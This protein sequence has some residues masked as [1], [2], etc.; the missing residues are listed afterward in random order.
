MKKH[1]LAVIALASFMSFGVVNK[2]T[3]IKVEAATI[4][5]NDYSTADSLHASSDASGLLAELRRLTSPGKSGAYGD[6]WNTYYS[7]FTKSDNFIMDYYSNISKFTESNRDR[8]S[9]GNKEGEYFNREHSV[10]QSW[11]GGGTTTGTQGTDP[12]I[13]IPSDKM[14]NGKRGSMSYGVVKTAS[15]SSA[16]GFSKTGLS[17]STAF[18]YSGTVFEP[19]DSV[20]G[21]LARNTLYAIAKYEKSYSWTSD[22]GSAIFSGNSSTNFGLTS[23]GVKLLTAWN[24]LDKPDEW[25]IGVNERVSKIQKNRNPF[26]DHPE[27]VNTL[28]GNVSGMTPYQEDTSPKLKISKTSLDVYTTESEELTGYMTDESAIT[29]SISDSTVASISSTTAKTITVTGLKAGTTTI[30]LS[31]HGEDDV[32]LEKTCTVTVKDNKVERL[33]ISNQKTQ[34]FVGDDFVKPTV[35]AMYTKGN[36]IDVT[37]EATFSG[38]N[39]TTA[40][41]RTISVSYGGKSTTYNVSI[42]ERPAPKGCG[43]NVATTSIV[44]SSLALAG[45]ITIVIVSITRKKRTADK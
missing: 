39:S 1:I 9:G 7:C 24:N 44:L 19:D 43:G 20:K 28:W 37:N 42:S 41:T 21:D 36:E 18:G 6:L 38:F 11:W 17:D 22:G 33:S 14:V 40:G 45:I 13:V 23:Y 8:G 2:V 32:L 3:T 10:P 30:T 16:N 35:K 4:D 31:G 25:E 15:F 12:Y 34:Y 26:I 27:Y 5:I 29:W